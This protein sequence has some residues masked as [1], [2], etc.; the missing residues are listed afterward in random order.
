VPERRAL[1]TRAVTDADADALIALIAA[2]YDEH[3]GCVLDLP[4]VDDDLPTPATAAARRGGRWWVIV[5]EG[6]VVAS[7]G[8]GPLT[9]AGT[10]ELKRL[11]V[12]PSHRGRGVASALVRRVETHAA[13]L[14]ATAVDLWSD[15]RFGDAHH[16]YD[17]RGYADTGER[18]QLH[19]P[20]DTTEIHFHRELEP[21]QPR[22]RVA[23]EGPFGRETCA[24]FD[25]PDG[26]VFRGDV[27]GAD[28][29]YAVEVDAAW[30]TRTTTVT[31]PTGT[32]RLASDGAGSWW[33]GG[34]EARSLTGCGAVDIEATPVTNT[35][36]IRQLGD[37]DRHAADLQAAWVRVPGPDVVSSTQRYVDLGAGRWRYTSG[38]FAADLTVD[39][40][41]LVVTYGDIWRRR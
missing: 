35:L 1:T 16:L 22:R 6:R 27:E 3:P 41:G 13:G 33:L 2:A 4:G 23:W 32:R 39:E 19:D 12:T 14:G 25:L 36:P 30:R 29:T 20:S 8:T 24:V 34:Q 10:V 40:D 7:V 28:L 38:T 17:R 21:A 15:T 26:A 31:D 5:D 18:R 11:Y 37:Q 9:D